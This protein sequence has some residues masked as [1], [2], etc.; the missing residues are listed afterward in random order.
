MYSYDDIEK[1]KANLEWIVHQSSANSRPPALSDR[2]TLYSLME[3]IQT[4]EGLLELII[5]YGM[6][7]VDQDVIEG[8]SLTETFI[9][10]VKSNANAS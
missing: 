8:L 6:T 4:Y 9:A 2:K 7:V 5:Q 10:K 1:I 3:L